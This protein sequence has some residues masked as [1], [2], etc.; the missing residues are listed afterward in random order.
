MWLDAR[1]WQAVVAGAFLAMGWLV[2]GWQNRR[3][4]AKLRAER[5]RDAHRALYAE[6][7]HNLDNLGS[8]EQLTEYR[9]SM[10]ARM[11]ENDSFVPFIPRE[12]H[13]T[14]FKAIVDE[15]YVL[16]RCSI[17]PV[18]GYYSQL[19]A[20]E[21]LIDDMR[22]ETFKTMSPRRRSEIYS[23]YIAIKL[24]ALSYGRHALSM[25][26]AFARGGAEEAGRVEKRLRDASDQGRAQ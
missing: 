11:E 16:P 12:R 13:N 8:A 5:L 1:I 26:D 9:E 18:V 7:Q 23:D 24:Q 4:A 2:N 6:I 3:E 10:L 14:V 21:M 19:A 25:I 22:G 17:D 20:L 15:I